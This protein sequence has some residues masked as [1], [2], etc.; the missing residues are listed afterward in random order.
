MSQIALQRRRRRRLD[1]TSFQEEYRRAKEF[2]KEIKPQTEG[3]VD[4]QGYEDKLEQIVLPF[5]K[6]DEIDVAELLITQQERLEQILTS[7][8]RLEDEL[9]E[10][11]ALLLLAN[12][13]L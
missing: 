12:E 5:K 9:L 13:E 1:E 8:R 7:I 4:V 3:F 2:F 10:I 6:G 11:L